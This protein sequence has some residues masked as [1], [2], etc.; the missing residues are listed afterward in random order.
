MTIT[1]AQG[2]LDL[3]MFSD[4]LSALRSL[5]PELQ[6]AGAA[7][8]I[9]ARASAA[10]GKWEAAREAADLIRHGN[11]VDRQEAAACYQSLAAEHFKHGR[12]DEARNFL[13]RAIATRPAQ[14]EAIL[15]DL[16]FG[17][18]FLAEFQRPAE[19]I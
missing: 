7:L 1:Q 3:G 13:K 5:P 2:L 11:E 6:E 8:R 19:V 4:A 10:L 12:N 14:R 16:R 9:K 18:R 17:E 15:D